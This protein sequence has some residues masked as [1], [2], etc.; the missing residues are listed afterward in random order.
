MLTRRGLLIALAGSVAATSGCLAQPA[1]EPL[2][3]LVPNAPGGGYDTTARVLAGA[4]G[5]DRDQQPTEVFNLPGGG[6]VVGLARLRTER[7]NA[8]L[9]MM[10]GLGVIGAVHAAGDAGDLDEVTPIARL[11]GE[12]EVVLVKAG[13]PHRTF[14]D[15]RTAWTGAPRTVTVGGGS[16]PGGPDH[17]ATYAIADAAGIPAGAVRYRAYDGGGP[18]LA[19]LVGGEVDVVVSGVL[20]TIDQVRSGAVRALAVTGEQSGGLEG[21]PTLR[22]Q[23]L[24]VEF[25]NW[26]GLLAPPGLSAAQRDH[27]VELVRASVASPQWQAVATRNGWT[28][29]WLDGDDFGRFLLAEEERTA[30]L[31][32]EIDRSGSPG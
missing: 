22:E 7:G 17:L 9:M 5:R 31:L 20:E 23:G 11:L 4:L 16:T 24:G 30:R 14:T 12:A 28:E 26:R 25:E 1:V 15:L 21:V 8:D 32:A 10:M 2:R 18:Q 13:S 29:R 19:A 27:L 3:L 6:G